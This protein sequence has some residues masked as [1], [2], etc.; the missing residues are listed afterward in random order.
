MICVYSPNDKKFK[1]YIDISNSLLPVSYQYKHT[2]FFP[3]FVDI[4]NIKCSTNRIST[5][6]IYYF[7]SK[8]RF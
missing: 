1:F 5:G 8:I 7:N 2:I 3:G 4:R 6:L